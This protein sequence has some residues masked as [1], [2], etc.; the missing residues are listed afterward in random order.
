MKLGKESITESNEDAL[1]RALTAGNVKLVEEL[2]DSGL[3]VDCCFSFGWTPLM[4]A[5]SVANLEMVRVLLN[6]G[7][8]A[9]FD[10]DKFT[11]LMS[12]CTARGSEEK[13]AKCV[14][15]LLSRNADPNVACR[16]Q[17][18]PLMFAAKEGNCQV[19]T[20]LIGHGANINAQDENGYTALTWAA[21]DGHKGMVLKLLELGADKS[22][23]TTSGNT[24]ADI[25]KKYNHLEIFSILS[26]S[27]NINHGKENVSK[28][29]A[30]YRYLKTQSDTTANCTS[31]YFAS[32]DLDIFLHGLGLEHLTN[33][34]TENDISLR[35]LLM[36]EEEELKKA[37]LIDPDDC[38]KIIAAVKEIQVEDLKLEASP[39]NLGLESS[40][41]ELFAFLLK[42]N[43]QCNCLTH[44]VQSIN[45]QIP[46]NPYKVVFEWDS[47]QNISAVCNDLVSSVTDL[48]KE[49]HRLQTLLHQFQE[50]QKNTCTRVPPLQEQLGWKRYRRVLVGLLALGFI[51]S[52]VKTTARNNIFSLPL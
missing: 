14:E 44:S 8:N 7:A 30:I 4:Y 36:L 25:A 34:F 27:A 18:T 40:N 5:A 47:T 31:G 16:K 9:S 20:L 26:L 28:E 22:L 17:M 19:V 15:L 24:P 48:G 33:V 51:V 23:V 39:N 42:L 37:G 2:L 38:Q 46:V 13:S 43:R 45:S 6:R 1:K 35:Q 29:E 32:S 50:G 21:H 12:A 49:V 10:R 41:D 52:A 11:V 3:S